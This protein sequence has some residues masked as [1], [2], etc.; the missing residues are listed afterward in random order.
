MD[1]FYQFGLTQR[2]LEGAI[3]FGGAAIVIGALWRYIIVGAGL[4]LCIYILAHHDTTDATAVVD[5]AKK[6]EMQ[7]KEFM[8]DCLD[9]AMNSKDQ[10]EI[11]WQERQSEE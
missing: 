11:I 2:M 1:F 6:V 3:I 4:L 5:P 7:R 10:C 9:V 8:K